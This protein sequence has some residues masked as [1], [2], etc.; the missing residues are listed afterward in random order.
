MKVLAVFLKE[1]EIDDKFQILCCDHDE[2]A[3]RT[4][5]GQITDEL[6]KEL[7]NNVR[8]LCEGEDLASCLSAVENYNDGCILAEW[9]CLD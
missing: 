3:E 1:I 8:A 5:R 7:E 4:I 6:Y 2:R 9:G